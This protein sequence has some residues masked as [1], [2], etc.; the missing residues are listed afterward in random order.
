MRFADGSTFHNF[1]CIMGVRRITGLLLAV[2][3]G[4]TGL[5]V[6]TAPGGAAQ[7]NGSDGLST[8]FCINYSLGGPRMFPFDSTGDGVADICSLPYTQR[9]AIARQFAMRKLIENLPAREFAAALASACASL[10]GRGFGD[11]TPQALAADACATG[12]IAPLPRPPANSQRFFSGPVVNGPEFCANFSLRQGGPQ[13]FPLDS[14]RDGVA[15]ICS[16]PYTRREAVARQLAMENLARKYAEDLKSNLVSACADL[17]GRR[18][19]DKPR[20]LNNDVCSAPPPPPAAAPGAPTNIVTTPGNQQITI[21]WAIAAS[22]GAPITA[23]TVARKPNTTACPTTLDNT[24]TQQTTTATTLTITGLTNGTIQRLCLRA[25][26]SQGNGPWATAI[27]TP[28]AAPGAP[29]NIV[30]TPGNQQA[31]ITW[32][33]APD[34][35]APITA[36]TVARKPN[37]TACP[38]TL[39]N[40]WTQQT[41]TE[42]ALTIT[43]LT[44]GIPYRV[45]LRATNSQGNG[46][47]ATAIATA[48]AAPGAPTNIVISSGNQQITITWTAAP[49]NG[50]P[51]TA[52]TIQYCTVSGSA[53]AGPWVDSGTTATTSHTITELANGA[54]YGVRI[55]ASNTYGDGNWSATTLG[56]T[57]AKA[58]NAPSGLTPTI[59]SRQIQLRWTAPADNGAPITAYTVQCRLADRGTTTG[60][61]NNNSWAPHTI[62]TGTSTTIT[63]LNNGKTYEIRVRATNS[64]GNS[65]WSTVNTAVS[66][67]PSSPTN[68]RAVTSGRSIAVSWSAP[69]S[70]GLPVTSYTVDY[71][72]GGCTS[73]STRTVSGNPPATSTTLTGLRTSSTYNVRIQA[74]NAVGSS[75]WS[76]STSATTPTPP[77][78]PSQLRIT[79][80]ASAKLTISFTPSTSVGTSAPTGYNAQICTARRS[81]GGAWSCSSSWR[82]IEISPVDGQTNT[83]RMAGL[84]G[85][86]DYSV[87]VQA[88]NAAGSSDWSNVVTDRTA[89]ITAPASPT[90]FT[91]TTGNGFI[92]MQW[93]TPNT[94]GAPI[95]RYTVGC[96]SPGGTQTTGNCRN[97]P[98]TDH[99]T[100]SGTSIT[101]S[102]LNN[103]QK[104]SVRVKAH[105]SKGHG[106]WSTIENITPAALPSAPTTLTLTESPS[107]GSTLVAKWSGAKR[108]GSRITSY[109]LEYR[110]RG[111]SWSLAHV[112]SART[113]DLLNLRRGTTYEVRVRA[114]NAKGT[115]G[116]SHVVSTLLPSGPGK[117]AKPSLTPGAGQI[118]ANWSAP[119]HTGESA[120]TGYNVQRCTARTNNNV[121]SCSG[122]WVTVTTSGSSTTTDKDTTSHKI[123]GLNAGTLYGVRVQA[124]NAAGG[125]SWSDIAFA[126]TNAATVPIAPGSG[127][128]LTSGDRSITVRWPAF[129]TGG[130]PI[131]RYTVQCKSATTQTTGSCRS[132]DYADYRTTSSTSMTISGLNNAV[133]YSVQ[134]KATNRVGNSVPVELGE[135]T[136]ATRP[137]VTDIRFVA[138][139]ENDKGTLTV[140]W[141]ANDNGSPIT[142]YWVHRSVVGGSRTLVSVVTEPT[143]TLN[144]DDLET[145]QTYT[146][147]I[148]A[149]NAMG[150]SGE[151]SRTT[152]FVLRP[153]E[154]LK[155]KLR[156]DGDD[157]FAWWKEP[158]FQGG[159]DTK[160]T[161]Y[162]LQYCNRATTKTNGTYDS[163]TGSWS[164]DIRRNTNT[165]SYRIT[166]PSSGTIYAVRVRALNQNGI[167]DW[168]R[169]EVITTPTE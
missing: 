39:D 84:S 48:S 127:W 145:G 49:D 70:G 117:P 97:N 12:V 139:Y 66:D 167:S 53:C 17:E 45:C 159:G 131:L 169:Y 31:T 57:I 82:S 10:Q 58:P 118:T 38:T 71:C 103:G 80:T 120:I 144:E 9:E 60:N 21:T 135:A 32:A 29:T 6:A 16:L 165:K 94:G 129:G 123:T 141:E 93:N 125:G 87:R 88:V 72:T 101:I 79:N 33:A 147:Y 55:R 100:T 149:E 136:P 105:N 130:A 109:T 102:N 124:V 90:D 132:T 40:T 151:T 61:C 18:F 47:W 110:P 22:N 160:V 20:D 42:N 68:L 155:L 50:A 156:L 43:S 162:I 128:T 113:K 158:A 30:T 75:A 121:K 114:T 148:E 69:A 76:R 126:T 168:G 24:W 25:T 3:L 63:T 67:R 13:M 152:T 62:V 1:R 28:S 143:I 108:N 153:S 99:T 146:F 140:S 8:E 106:G 54:P 107:V 115:S 41:T 134:V 122:S 2:A 51:I 137:T 161:G 96:R 27:A 116:W 138:G 142:S 4:A 157:I 150:K 119:A 91:A 73:W 92:R 23:Y 36:Y 111:G 37:T 11:D 46:P 98:W 26:N 85:E 5:L 154:P 112:G 77:S 35:G 65:P 81:S 7:S 74:S 104:Y 89:V 44:N 52:Y 34:N 56:R 15:D 19:A 166:D 78:K 59:S 83:Y 86:T 64:V 133:A 163:C 95:T 14:N 164:E